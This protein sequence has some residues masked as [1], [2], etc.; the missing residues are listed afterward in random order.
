MQIEPSADIRT[1]ALA[2]FQMHTA[3][4]QAGFSEEQAFE[5]TRTA[6]EAAFRGG[7]K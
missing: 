1:A 4:S 6:V 3:F 5:L 7:Q 2:F